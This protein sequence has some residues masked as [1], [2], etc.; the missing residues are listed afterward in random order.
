MTGLLKV[1]GMLLVGFLLVGFVLMAIAI[2]SHAGS[3]TPKSRVSEAFQTFQTELPRA[4]RLPPS[5]THYEFHHDVW[6]T[7]G[8]AMIH[9]ECAYDFKSDPGEASCQMVWAHI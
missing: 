7:P 1:A 3:K 5:S 6:H 9:K 8:K 4:P 2:T